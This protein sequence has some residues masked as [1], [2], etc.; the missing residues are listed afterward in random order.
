M[1]VKALLSGLSRSLFKVLEVKMSRLLLSSVLIALVA[2]L[3]L[4]ACVVP[5]EPEWIPNIGDELQITEGSVSYFDPCWFES[6]DR[7]QDGE[8]LPMN[9]ITARIVYH[10]GKNIYIHFVGDDSRNIIYT[11]PDGYTATSVDEI[12]YDNLLISFNDGTASIVAYL[13]VDTNDYTATYHEIYR[14]NHDS[15]I[16]SVVGDGTNYTER[17][18]FTLLCERN[19]G[20]SYYLQTEGD[21]TWYGFFYEGHDIDATQ[22]DRIPDFVFIEDEAPDTNVLIGHYYISDDEA[23]ITVRV[24][25]DYDEFTEEYCRYPESNSAVTVF[26]ENEPDIWNVNQKYQVTDKP[27]FEKELDS[28]DKYIVFSREVDGVSNIHVVRRK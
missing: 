15:L 12:N 2:G 6:R 13:D 14:D 22:I 27:G 8:Y 20:N 10:D 24:L 5:L 3:T 16:S 26:T 18:E 25:H 7:Y 28:T 1:K 9:L 11:V 4:L 21:E 17:N 19:D 23:D